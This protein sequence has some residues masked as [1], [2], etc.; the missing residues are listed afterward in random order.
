MFF[1][2][3]PFA[4]NPIK[5]AVIEEVIPFVEGGTVIQ[6][7]ALNEKLSKTYKDMD[8]D[9]YVKWAG[10][11]VDAPVIIK[12]KTSPI[13]T[14]IPPDLK[15]AYTKSK[16]LERAIEDYL[17]ENSVCKC[18]PCQ[19]GGTVIVLDGECVCK[20]QRHYTGV[21]C[22]TPKSD[23]LPNSKPQ[24]DGRWSCWSPSSCKNGEITL[25]RQCNN[26]AAQ[27]GGHSCHG[28]NRKSV[29]C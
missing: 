28:E 16:N 6:A 4:D 5:S 12:S 8:V 23:I 21:A 15:D 20:C 3:N 18:Q 19:N 1:Y 17:E 22:Q 26:P 7:T 29:P 10:T 11:I 25:T 14:L 24:V 2:C 27:N 13:Y 9:D